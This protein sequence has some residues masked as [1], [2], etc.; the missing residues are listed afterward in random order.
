MED[1]SGL[2]SRLDVKGFTL[3]ELLVVVLIIGILAA[4]A[5]PQYKVAVAKS[6]L[7]TIRPVL[8]SVKQAE[9]AYYMANGAYVDDWGVLSLDL[10][11]CKRQYL[12]IMQCGNFMVDILEGTGAN[13]RAVYCPSYTPV[14]DYA[15]WSAC[16][17][18][19]ELIYRV[20]FTDSAF[21]DKVECIAN[22]TLGQKVCNSL[23]L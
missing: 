10:S 5:L 7:A 13:A 11:Q 12:D 18:K 14:A 2:L 15:G 19:R 23:H 6:R 8:A 22:T 4:V 1:K 20:W 17:E 16:N 21:P 3:I 9:E